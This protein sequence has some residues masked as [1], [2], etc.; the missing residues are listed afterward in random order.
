MGVFLKATGG[1][2][3]AV[4]LYLVI[5]KQGKELSL[6]LTIAVC[7]MVAVV[8]VGFLQPVIEFV[9]RL[10][11]VG[12]LDSDLLTTVLRSVGIGILSEV[13]ALICADAGNASLGKVLQLLG[14]AVILGMAIPLFSSL[15]S[16][17]EEILIAV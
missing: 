8:A 13:T 2:L 3:I 15:L 16:L 4:V 6:L 9:F 1:V 7:C 17:I 12:Q 5:A 14:C 10:Q 11:S